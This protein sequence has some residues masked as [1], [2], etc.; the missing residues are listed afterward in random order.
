ML[1]CHVTP[2]VLLPSG[3][4]KGG[5]TLCEVKQMLFSCFSRFNSR[6]LWV[7]DRCTLKYLKWKLLHIQDFLFSVSYVHG[8]PWVR[9]WEFPFSPCLMHLSVSC[10]PAGTRYTPASSTPSSGQ[11]SPT[12]CLWITSRYLRSWRRLVI[13]R[14]WLAS[15]T[16]GFTA[17]NACPRSEDLTRSLARS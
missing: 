11:R 5:A 10:L 16:W 15:G 14:T 9:A 6:A 17:E 12:A 3:Q 2:L 13:Q 7:F 8:C 1:L 4:K